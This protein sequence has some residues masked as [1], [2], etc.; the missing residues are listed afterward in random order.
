L[1]DKRDKKPF[2]VTLTGPYLEALDY[3]V[4]EGIYMDP[5]DA[6]KE[7]LR[8]LFRHHKIE[9]FTDK[10]SKLKKDNVTSS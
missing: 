9:P 2:S 7:A 5:Q 10:R 4:N 3:L 8:L 1:S 6:I